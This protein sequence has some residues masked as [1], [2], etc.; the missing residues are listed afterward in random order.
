[1]LRKHQCQISSGFHW[2]VPKICHGLIVSI[3][4]HEDKHEW[5][6]VTSSWFLVPLD[7]P[8]HMGYFGED[9]PLFSRL[10]YGTYSWLLQGSLMASWVSQTLRR[11]SGSFASFL[12][13]GSCGV[14][15]VTQ[16]L[17]FNF[18]GCGSCSGFK[19]CGSYAI[20]RKNL[21]TGE[22]G[23]QIAGCYVLFTNIDFHF[24]DKNI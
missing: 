12:Q 11:Q 10:F 17:H 2:G 23:T 9:S 7:W 18:C 5:R 22:I 8:K 13:P 16:I 4:T 6:S 20:T 14:V 24:A 1:M 15:S 3:H 19:G 21:D